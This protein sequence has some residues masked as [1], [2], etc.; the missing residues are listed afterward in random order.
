M[1]PKYAQKSRSATMSK[2]F[3]H[4]DCG[5]CGYPSVV[6][7]AGLVAGRA[8]YKSAMTLAPERRMAH[9]LRH[10]KGKKTT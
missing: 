3:C 10:K 1:D 8:A 9:I 5:K 6:P 4:I 2:G 7:I